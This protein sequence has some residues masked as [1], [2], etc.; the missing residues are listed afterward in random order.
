MTT[1]AEWVARGRGHQQQARPVD[2]MLCYRRAIR[3]DTSTADAHLHLGEVLWQLKRPDEAIGA[4]REAIRLAP[5]QLRAHLA[6]TEATLARA[7]FA[8]AEA[9]AATGLAR[10]P[11]VAPALLVAGIAALANDPQ[12][13]GDTHALAIARVEEALELDAGLLKVPSLAGPLATV[14]D[15]LS[16]ATAR[17]R[18]GTKVADLLARSDVLASLP[19]LLLA[20]VIERVLASADA[21]NA[22]T[23]LRR[24]AERPYGASEHDPVRRMALAAAR[25]HHH[26]AK[27]LAERYARICAEAFG[28]S[29]PLL[30]PRRTAGSALRVLVLLQDDDLDGA[31][32]SAITTLATRHS[33]TLDVTFVLWPSSSTGD[34]TMASA[35]ATAPATQDAAV[36]TIRLPPGASLA[37]ARQLG[38]LDADVLIDA[39]GLSV[40]AGPLLATR[41]ARAVWAIADMAAPLPGPWVDETRAIAVLEQALTARPVDLPTEPATPGPEAMAVMFHEAVRLHQQHDHDTAMRAYGDILELQPGHVPTLYLRGALRR[42]GGNLDG[43][44]ADNLAALEVAPRYIDARLAAAQAALDTHQPEIAIRIAARNIASAPG[45]T[46]LWRVLGLAHLA[47]GEGEAAAELFEHALALELTDAETHYNHGVALQMQRRFGDAARAYQRALAFRPDFVAADFN[48]GVLFQEQGNHDAAIAAYGQVVRADPAHVTAYKNLGEVLFASGKLDAWRANFLRFEAACPQALPLAVQALEVCQHFADFEGVERYLD[49]LRNERYTA[50]NPAE[51]AES[52]EE[53]LYLLLFFDVE[54]EILYR[55]AQ[56]YDTTARSLYGSPMAREATRRPGRWR[57]GYLSA[58]LRNHVMGKMMW[59][60]IHHHDRDRFEVFCYSTSPQE[61]GWTQRFRECVDH[62]VSLGS[63]RDAAAVERMAADDL[64]ILVDLS[65]H[66]RGAR[67]ALLARKPARV[68]LTHVASAGAVGLSA[69]DFKLTDHFADVPENQAH[70]VERLLPMAG[71]VYPYRHIPAAPVHA[72]QRERLGIPADAFVLGAFVTPMKLSRRCLRLWREVLERV[73][74]ARLA[75]SPNSPALRGSFLRLADAAGISRERIVQIP[76]GKDEH[77]NQARYTLIDCVLDP[78]PFGGVNGS[79]EALD[80]WVPVVTLCG[81]KH[82]ERTTTSILANLGVLDTVAH[83][84]PEYVQLTVRLAE[85]VA[86][87]ADVRAKIR[88]GLERS[89]LTDMPT[90]TRN[91]EAAYLHAL[92]LVNADAPRDP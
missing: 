72:Y 37:E 55:F 14:L 26:E 49:G 53:L 88:R 29:V 56:T 22:D 44:L 25:T 24:A 67:P 92:E 31:S 33:A 9:A 45:F 27:R 90:H 82:G 35:S 7:D 40:P 52:L 60:A 48:L 57:I 10:F 3:L 15:G 80:M 36:R 21:S 8:A 1:A 71:C 4:W 74:R 50:R 87:A 19:A 86:F 76:Q 16:D 30:W 66:T 42:E 62:F 73:P 58:D 85:D 23:L 20:L 43:A 18:V 64:D 2:A 51:L 54:P 78:L 59:A 69:I 41:P 28:P 38:W 34:G 91:L 61:D 12:G 79:L 77:E 75:I 17:Q 46:T 68:A 81:R 70:V 5:D 89:L 63:L 47:R 32:G 13:D 83:S 11:G 84:G 6:L 65:T 39:V